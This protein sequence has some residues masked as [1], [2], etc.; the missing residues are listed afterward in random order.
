MPPAQIRKEQFFRSTCRH[1]FYYG[2]LQ[3]AIVLS[4]FKNN[5]CITAMV[6]VT[7]A[8]NGSNFTHALQILSTSTFTNMAINGDKQRRIA[9]VMNKS[10]TQRANYDR[11]LK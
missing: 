8:V 7:T 1:L 6:A 10:V 9:K 11:P 5:G 4:D 2:G 3:C